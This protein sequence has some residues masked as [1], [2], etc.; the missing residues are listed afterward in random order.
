VNTGFAAADSEQH[1]GFAVLARQNTL[2]ENYRMA[3]HFVG[4]AA[5]TRCQ[6]QVEY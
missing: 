5:S 3:V 6:C 2:I 1:I 4:I